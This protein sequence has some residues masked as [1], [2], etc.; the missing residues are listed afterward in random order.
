MSKNSKYKIQ[1][2]TSNKPRAGTNAKVFIEL[3]GDHGNS[4]FFNFFIPEDPVRI[5]YTPCKSKKQ[6]K[7]PSY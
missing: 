2:V 6:K 4:G 7:F 3:F 1:T 5:W